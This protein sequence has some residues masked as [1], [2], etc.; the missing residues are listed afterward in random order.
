MGVVGFVARRRLARHWRAMAAAGVLL[1]LGFGLSL[2]SFAAARRTASAYDR[3]LVEAD[4]PDAAVTL[5]QPP[6]ESEQ[7]LGAIEGI[8]DQR[9]YAGF[10]GAADGVDPTVVDRR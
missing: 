6:E 7:S 10:I 9:V 3:I 4:A 2:A 8:T 5:G 1:G